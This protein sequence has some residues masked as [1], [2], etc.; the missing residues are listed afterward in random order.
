MLITVDV[1]YAIAG[2]PMSRPGISS[3]KISRLIYDAQHGSV[4]S[5]PVPK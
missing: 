3:P 5:R 4:L 2:P 1:Y